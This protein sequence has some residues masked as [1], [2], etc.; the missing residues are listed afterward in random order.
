MAKRSRQGSVQV[1]TEIE[2]ALERF[3]R[4]SEAE[5]AN[6]ASCL[7]DLK[8]STGEQWDIGMLTQ[9]QLAKKPSLTLD[10]MQQ[11]I[12]L[13]SNQYRQ[14]PPALQVNPL[15][16]GATEETA[17]IVQGIYRHIDNI[18]DSQ[19]TYESAHEGVVRKGFS[20]WRLLNEYADDD[21]DEQEIYVKKIRNDFSVYWEPGVPHEDAKWAFIV[22]DLPTETFQDQYKDSKL[23]SL[24][25]DFTAIGN[26]QPDWASKDSIRIAEYFTVEEVAR[27]GKRPTKKVVWRKINVIEVLE[28]PIDLP[29]T[30][31]PIFTAYGDDLDVDGKRYIAGLVRNAKDAQRLVNYWASKAT[32]AI[33]LAP[34]APWV[35][36]EGQLAGRENEWEKANS[37]EMQVLTYKQV[38]I[39]GKP[40]PEPKRSVVEPAVQAI[41]GMLSEAKLDLKAAMGIYDPSLGQ[42]KGDESGAAIKSLQTQGSI[43]TLNFSDNVGR[44][45]RREGRV[46][47]E[48]IRVIYDGAR[49]QRIINPDGSVKQVVTHNGPDQEEEAKKLAEQEGIKKIYDIG[50]GTYDIA[51]SVGPT[52]QSKRQEAVATQM[53]FLKSLPPQIVP[54]LLDLVMRNMDIPQN[55][56]I[57]DRLKKMLP[58]QLQ[59]GDDSDPE[60]RA[61]KAEA[62]VQQLGQQHQQLTQALQQATQ[63]IHTKQVEQQG[64]LEA[65]KIQEASAQTI[66]KMQLDAKIAIAEIDA[67]AQSMSERQQWVQD[68]WSELH[69]SAHEAALQIQDQTHQK[70]MADQQAQQAQQT[71][72]SD[73]QHEQ[74]MAQRAQEAQPEQGAE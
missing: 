63:E 29:G 22:E 26:A 13:V 57:A 40:A 58:P 38:D 19:V 43:A 20:S 12:R 45:M 15:G 44:E 56:E 1:P 54:L 59:G 49:V 51:F 47:L 2:Q 35:L 67:K 53:D 5:Y 11:S 68:I 27:E 52:Y 55:N 18:S 64:K 73:Q 23:A 42:R 4:A 6:R 60:V 17:D 7:D 24:G 66:Q 16:N 65:V 41:T 28:K 36:V 71:Q 70:A 25:S 72:Q 10:Q 9:R 31:I 30:S 69:G 46:R 62:Q 39:S 48:W 37:G 74:G 32:E 8:F 33:A 14:Q 3:K 21:S 61:Q 50:T 34:T